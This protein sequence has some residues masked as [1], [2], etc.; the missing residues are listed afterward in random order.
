M[1]SKSI[2]KLLTAMLVVTMLIGSTLTVAAES[3]G[4]SGGTEPGPTVSEESSGKDP[5]V[6]T[7][8]VSDNSVDSDDS[9]DSEEIRAEVSVAAEQPAETAGTSESVPEVPAANFVSAGGNVSVAGTAVKSTVAGAIK[10]D[11]LRGVAVTTPLAEVKAS[12]GLSGSQT[13]YVIVFDTNAKKSNL[14]MNCVN[15]AA[16]SLGGQVVSAI[17]VTLGAKEKGKIISLTNGSAGMVVG[18]PKNA[19]TARTYSVVCVQPGGV[20][21]ILS[22]QD[23]NP[24]TVTFAVKAGLGTYGIVA[25]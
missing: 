14:A 3:S 15:A 7:S 5:V 9:D 16:E 18:L 25:K 13:P 8:S 10:V 19:D 2:K 6:E 4:S 12:L 21:T 1:K 17:N 20:I 11:T 22:D 23:S 24:A